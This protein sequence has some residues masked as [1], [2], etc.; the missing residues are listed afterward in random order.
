[1]KIVYKWGY[2]ARIGI[3]VAGSTGSATMNLQQE[4]SETRQHKSPFVNGKN[5]YNVAIYRE[6]VPTSCQIIEKILIF[7]LSCLTLNKFG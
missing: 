1:M 3:P 4:N 5:K 2:G 6:W 7:L